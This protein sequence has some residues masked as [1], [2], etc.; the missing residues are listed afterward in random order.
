[1]G[2]ADDLENLEDLRRT[3]ALTQDEYTVAKAE[4]LGTGTSA[5]ADP[6]RDR[7]PRSRKRILVGS[8]AAAVLVTGGAVAALTFAGRDSERIDQRAKTDCEALSQDL[9]EQNKPMAELYPTMRG[10]GCGEWLDEQ[11]EDAANQ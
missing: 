4:L 11:F 5:S 9:L 6:E 7:S 1:M 2:L 8:L 3:G 10:L